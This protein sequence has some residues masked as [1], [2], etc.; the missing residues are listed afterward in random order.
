MADLRSLSE[1]LR[2]FRGLSPEDK[3]EMVFL[4]LQTLL[5]VVGSMDKHL[6]TLNGSTRTVSSALDWHLEAHKTKSDEAAGV[7][8]LGGNV[9]NWVIAL[10]AIATGGFGIAEVVQRMVDH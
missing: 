7:K 10:L 5:G 4:D 1:K 2:D 8:M 9:K 6:D 3:I